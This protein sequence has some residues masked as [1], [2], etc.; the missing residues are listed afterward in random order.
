MKRDEIL[1]RLSENRLY[2]QQHFDVEKV[3][4][5]G[6]YAKGVATDRSDIDIYVEFRHKSFDNV[7]GLWTFLEDLY[8][9]KVDLFYRHKANN[10]VILSNIQREVI[11]G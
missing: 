8:G 9:K 4:L 1:R 6:S 11:Y 10:S 3:G 2:I 5:F 7:V